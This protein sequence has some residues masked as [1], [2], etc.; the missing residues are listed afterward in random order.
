MTKTD[1]VPNCLMFS[2]RQQVMKQ[3]PRL[4]DHPHGNSAC[5]CD[6]ADQELDLRQ[7]CSRWVQGGGQAGARE[8]HP[9]QGLLG[10]GP[11]A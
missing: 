2:S 7:L 1:P 3:G 5:K 11:S 6:E 9:R 8:E 4:A 10:L